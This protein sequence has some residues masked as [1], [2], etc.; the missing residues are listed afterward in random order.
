LTDL[1]LKV[2]DAFGLHIPGGEHPE[3]A[4][5]VVDKS[6]MVRDRLEGAAPVEELEPSLKALLS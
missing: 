3:P 2:S 1:D 6:G 5:F 4:T